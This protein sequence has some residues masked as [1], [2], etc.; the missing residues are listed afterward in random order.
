MLNMN[1]WLHLELLIEE[2]IRT[3]YP[4]VTC[5][6]VFTF[7]TKISLSFLDISKIFLVGLVLCPI[8]FLYQWGLLCAKIGG[9]YID[10]ILLTGWWMTLKISRFNRQI[11]WIKC[12][13]PSF[14]TLWGKEHLYETQ[15]INISTVIVVR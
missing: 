3:Y 7:C 12:C 4:N 1:V 9:L 2:D 14:M 15:Y 6:E 5:K 10:V 8:Q 11:C 13:L